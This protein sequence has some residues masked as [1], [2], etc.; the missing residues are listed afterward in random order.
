[1]GPNHHDSLVSSKFG[2]S[3]AAGDTGQE[4]GGVCHL[5]LTGSGTKD[6]HCR[7]I[8]AFSQASSSLA[9]VNR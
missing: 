3:P 7:A 2:S 9:P 6:L 5:G 4:G 1:M 8:K